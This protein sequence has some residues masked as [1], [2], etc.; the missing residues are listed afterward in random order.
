MPTK[1]VVKEGE[2]LLTIAAAY[3][4]GDWQ[5]IWSHGDNAGL[6]ARRPDPMVLVA[7]DEVVVPDR[8][9][10]WERIET[11][12]RHVFKVEGL[13]A[14][15]RLL[16]EDDLGAPLQGG[17]FV[18]ETEDGRRRTGEVGPRGLVDCSLPPACRKATLT[19][20]LGKLVA[21]WHLELG[22]LEPVETVKGVQARLNALGLL[23]GRLTGEVDA[24]T[25]KAIEAFQRRHGLPVTGAADEAQLR[26]TLV[27][28]VL[29]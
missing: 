9:R 1:H 6:R 12:R 22:Q 2:T 23:D 27:E 26:D 17:A 7:G 11:N 5:T 14:R 28:R 8:E 16:V 24:P 13:E 25:R 15:L 3:G 29:V 4:F 10:R 19:V 20:T 21:T 18:V